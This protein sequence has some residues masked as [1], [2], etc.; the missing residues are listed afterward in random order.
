MF[1]FFFI[2]SGLTAF[3][4]FAWRKLAST[5]FILYFAFVG[6]LFL[7]LGVY[8]LDWIPDDV[9][10]IVVGIVTTY[11]M[12]L[13]FL[14]RMKANRKHSNPILKDVYTLIGFLAS[15]YKEVKSVNR[16]GEFVKE[17]ATRSNGLVALSF[18]GKFEFV[19]QTFADYL[20]KP[21]AWFYSVNY[22][23]LLTE[24]ENER[25]QAFWDKNKKSG[26]VE[27]HFVNWWTIDG[28]EYQMEWIK[29]FNDNDKKVAYCVLNV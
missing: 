16:H 2:L 12:H 21:V 3:E 11:K 6:F 5:S 15:E 22:Y 18:D 26:S 19:N 24:E 23:D 27:Q 29:I 4:V 8:S 17:F 1:I 7:T 20:G 10:L 14:N 9:L 28:V 13:F 25:S